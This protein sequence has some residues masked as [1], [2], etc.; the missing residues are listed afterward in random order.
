MRELIAGPARLAALE[1][2]P[3]EQ[4]LTRGLDR[5]H[6]VLQPRQLQ[7]VCRLGERRQRALDALVV[8]QAAF[9]RQHGVRPEAMKAE[10]PSVAIAAAS[11]GAAGPG[12][13]G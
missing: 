4:A 7:L 3:P 10:A 11:P 12:F 8:D 6:Q 2:Q 1:A 5:E 9:D 13:P